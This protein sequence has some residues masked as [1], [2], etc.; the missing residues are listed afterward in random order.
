MKRLI[1]FFRNKNNHCTLFRIYFSLLFFFIFNIYLILY[2]RYHWLKGF[3][4]FDYISYILYFLWIFWIIVFWQIFWKLIYDNFFKDTK[5]Y[6]TSFLILTLWTWIIFVI[7]LLIMLISLFNF[8][9][10]I[11]ID[12]SFEIFL[13]T[14]IYL[15]TW[16]FN[17]F[18][19]PYCI[20]ILFSSLV[21]LFEKWKDHDPGSITFILLMFYIII[22]QFL[23]WIPIILSGLT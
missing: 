4:E 14:T 13:Y 20:I 17:I 8:S 9:S 23:L 6:D 5:K 1:D 10:L 12:F 15:W 16:E 22:S 11:W 2:L 3:V 21:Y 18:S 7:D 19:L